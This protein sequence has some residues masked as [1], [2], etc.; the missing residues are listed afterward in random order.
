[1]PA[2]ANPTSEAFRYWTLNSADWQPAL[3][4]VAKQV[5][6]CGVRWSSLSCSSTHVVLGGVKDVAVGK[7]IVS[8]GVQVDMDRIAEWEPSA[9]LN[10]CLASDGCRP[11]GFAMPEIRIVGDCPPAIVEA[12]NALRT[13]RGR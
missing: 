7:K 9:R 4:M 1:M 10:I 8:A 11:A 6:A 3:I 5:D 12:F 13:Q 2:W